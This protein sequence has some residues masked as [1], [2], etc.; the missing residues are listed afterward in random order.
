MKFKAFPLGLS[1]LIVCFVNTIQPAVAQ[2]T[3]PLKSDSDNPIEALLN[4]AE[5]HLHIPYRSGGMSKKGF[6]CSGFVRYCYE[7]WNVLLPHSSAA[8][9]N[10]GEKVA[11]EEAQPG[12]L[13]FFKGSSVKSNQVGHVGIIT[14]VNSR[15]VRFIHSAFKGG[16]RYDVLNSDYYKKRFV[17][18]RRILLP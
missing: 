5:R 10:K 9:A 17:A 1:L 16:V 6:D 4:F 7:N 18:I 14:E 8:Q 13:I 2:S 3:S 12:D 15:Y 11:L